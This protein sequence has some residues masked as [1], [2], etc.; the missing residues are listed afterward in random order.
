MIQ[1]ELI[2][3]P[4]HPDLPNVTRK[5]IVIQTVNNYAGNGV[6]VKLEVFHYVDGQEV[7]YFKNRYVELMADNEDFVDP[8]T[9][10]KVQKDAEGNYPPGSI[11]EYDYLWGIVNV[12]KAKTQAELEDIYIT[13][14]IDSINQKLYTI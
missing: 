4:N 10:N 5:A 7:H 9:G 2:N 14:R 8:A 1:R 11:G 13:K 3:L 6:G 12:A